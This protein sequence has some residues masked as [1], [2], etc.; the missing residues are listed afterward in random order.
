M[1]QWAVI[2]MKPLNDAKS[3]LSTVLSDQERKALV[4]ALFKHTLDQFSTIHKFDGLSVITADPVLAGIARSDDVEVF[5]ETEPS[6]LNHSLQAAMPFFIKKKVNSLLVLPGD[7]PYIN[8]RVLIDME[9]EMEKSNLLMIAPDQHLSGT[10][11]LFFN[12]LK[13]MEF[14]FGEHSFIKHIENGRAAKYSIK[15]YFADALKMDID[16]P[17]DMLQHQKILN[18]RLGKPDQDVEETA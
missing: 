16:T 4:I 18:Y 7:L 17:E 14:F 1:K 8:T 2:P 15:L 11:A 10:N 5:E 6:N 9:H 13:K 3:R 12:P